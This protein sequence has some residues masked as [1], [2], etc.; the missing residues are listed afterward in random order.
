MSDSIGSLLA[1]I[2]R[3]GGH[4]TAAVGLAQS[5]KDAEK[6]VLDMRDKMQAME[7]E[8]E[9]PQ[10]PEEHSYC[11]C[12]VKEHIDPDAVPM[13]SHARRK[14][15]EALKPEPSANDLWEDLEKAIDD[16]DTLMTNAFQNFQDSIAVLRGEIEERKVEVEETE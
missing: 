5:C 16:A 10:S 3:D 8:L 9:Q 11:S 15:A 4:H 6:V 14:V 13:N 2:H 7:Y 12:R 1:V